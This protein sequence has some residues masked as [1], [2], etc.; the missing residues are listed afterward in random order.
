MARNII[1]DC[2]KKDITNVEEIDGKDYCFDCA[3]VIKQLMLL[4]I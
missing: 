4:H 2:D 3:T 1:Y